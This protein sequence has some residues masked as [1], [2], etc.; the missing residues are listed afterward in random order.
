ESRSRYWL[1]YD[2]NVWCSGPW[3]RDRWVVCRLPLVALDLFRQCSGRGDSCR[4]SP[5]LHS[6]VDPTYDIEC[7]RSRAHVDVDLCIDGNLQ[8]HHAGGRSDAVLRS[9]SCRTRVR[10]SRAA[11]FDAPPCEVRKGSVYSV[12]TAPRKRIW[13]GQ[14]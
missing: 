7:L 4:T 8:H 5:S 12:T 3:T 14:H 11:L 9:E 2:G 6:R 13:G 10:S 1:F